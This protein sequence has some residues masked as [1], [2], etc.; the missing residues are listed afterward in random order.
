M[1]DEPTYEYFKGKGWVPSTVR[2][3][4]V[5]IGL[6]RVTVYERKPEIGECYFTYVDN[7][8]R[9]MVELSRDSYWRALY[10]KEELGN[11]FSVWDAYAEKQYKRSPYRGLV[12]I[13]HELIV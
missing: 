4:S 1:S 3:H 9:L 11:N 10:S 5:N 6:W 8:P 7:I 13:K 2:G 12:T